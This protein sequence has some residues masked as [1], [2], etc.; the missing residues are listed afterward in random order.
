LNGLTNLLILEIKEVLQTSRQ[1]IARQINAELFVTYWNIGRVIV[2]HEQI[3]K[4]VQNMERRHLKSYQ[5]H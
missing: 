4:P 1:N 3:I 2:D 5:K